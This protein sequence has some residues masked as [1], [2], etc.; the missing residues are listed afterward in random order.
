VTEPESLLTG[1]RILDLTDELAV[2]G[3]RLLAEW[4]AEVIKVEPPEGDPLCREPP[5]YADVPHPEHSLSFLAWN[6]NKKSI[7]LNLQCADGQALFTT[8]LPSVDAVVVSAQPDDPLWDWLH[9]AELR[10]SHPGLVYTTASGFGQ[11]GPHATYRSSDLVAQAMGGFMWMSGHPDQPPMQPGGNLSHI[12]TGLYVATGTMVAL[13]HRQQTGEGQH[14]D[15][16]QQDSVASILAEFGASSY[17][18]TEHIPMRYGTHRPDFFPNGLYA[19]R[20][21]YLMLIVLPTDW[22]RFAEWVHE[23]TGNTTVLEERFLKNEDRVLPESRAVLNPILRDFTHQFPSKEVLFHAG[24]QRH[25][26]FAPVNTVADLL[27]D[28]Q[29][30]ARGFWQPLDVPG[31]APLTA[32]G[33]PIESTVITSVP[34]RSAPKL[35]Q[36]NLEIYVGE[37]GLS[38]YQLGVLKTNHII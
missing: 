14:V 12:L 32:A 6:T 10:H 24:Q 37:L 21:G 9:D 3:T 15:V 23:V 20:D 29:L 28:R 13:W 31:L 33:N 22:P 38:P 19:C 25:F 7:T 8:L 5:F 1:Y 16:S 17:W 11:E 35:G 4:S 36:H 30:Q 2:Y 18:A 26:L 27:R 34:L